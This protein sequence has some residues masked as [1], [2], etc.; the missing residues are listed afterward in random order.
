MIASVAACGVVDAE[1][2][3]AAA[4]AALPSWRA[5]TAKER[6]AVLR[7]WFEL[8]RDNTD[9]LATILTMEAG[10]PHPEAKVIFS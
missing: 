9:D 6:S 3:V 7:K 10:K 8:V 4:A 2:A 5:K 1:A